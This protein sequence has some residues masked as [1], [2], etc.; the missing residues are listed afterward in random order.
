DGGDPTRRA[1]RRDRVRMLAAPFSGAPSTLIDVGYR[2]SGIQ[3][4]RAGIAIVRESWIRTRRIREWLID[5][6]APNA[7]PQML[8]DRNSED[9][10]NDPGAY[11][12]SPG[13]SGAALIVTSADGKYAFRTAAGASPEGDRPFLDRVELRTGKSDRI[14]RSEGPYFEQVVALA[15]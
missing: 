5:L 2:Y 12:T 7:V 14:W 8:A 15:D 9:R 6:G 10:Y 13:A 3:W 4:T 11:V 1:E